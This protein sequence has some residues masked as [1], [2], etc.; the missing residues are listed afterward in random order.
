M[1]L[2]G[3][4]EHLPI[5]DVVQLIHST[6]KSGTLNVYS[7]RGEAQLVFDNGY[8][9]G[10][11]HVND[12]IRIGQILLE[13]EII[14]QEELD[15][16]LQIQESAG[17][18]RKPLIATLID[19]CD[20][21]KE[22]AYKGLEKLIEMTVVDMISW[23]RGIFSLD[24]DKISVT[25]DYRYLPSQLQQVTLDT[26]M[27]LMDALRIFDEKV[28]AGEIQIVDE[29]LEEQPQLLEEEVEN[30]Q[31][32]NEAGDVVLS[33]DILGL[34]DLDKIERKKPRVFKSLEAFDPTEI[35]RQVVNK[36]LPELTP[37]QSDELV[38][39]LAEVAL[40]TFDDE[41]VT[42]T[43]QSQAIILYTQDEFI[44]HAIITVC[45]RE[46]ILVFTT[47]D[48]SNLDPLIEKAL[49]NLL[50]PILV[51]GCPLAE[52]T[53]FDKET[54]IRLRK[55]KMAKYDQLSVI[56]LCSPLDYEFSLQSLNDGIRAVFPKPYFSERQETYASDAINFLNSFQRYIRGCF[57]AE[58][59]QHFARLRNSLSGLRLLTKAPD[60]SLSV[61]QF[62]SESF[63]RTLTLIVA[64]SE[65]IV[66]RSIGIKGEKGLGPAAP[67]GARLPLPNASTIAT[68]IADQKT[69]FGP[70]KD[71]FFAEQ[72]FPLIGAPQDSTILL[73]PLQSNDKT[74][75]LTYADFGAQSAKHVPIDFLE[76]FASQAAL[77]MEN[78]L[79]RKQMNKTSDR[80]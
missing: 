7:R 53:G 70:A 63:E 48:A 27:V 6:R 60:I 59:R 66:E 64:K 55:A 8:I 21:S 44:Q 2:T 54:I 73:L 80:P 72:L 10:A 1:P 34:A 68:A 52:K 23:T 45:K 19:H 37:A 33:E 9:V 25:D 28:H 42:S 26:Q 67:W 75:T 77:S 20:L 49:S 24:V 29:P 38:N 76:F 16:A 35:H 79:F 18:E 5:V 51:F 36:A 15:K 78:A 30:D 40:P 62:V 41:D 46:G 43:T 71:P 4:L 17:D 69:Y 47:E 57:N 3:E 11:S 50:E 22:T 58:R 39:F 12:K 56:Q 14:T 31:E 32:E 65:L 13:S 61:L 74:I